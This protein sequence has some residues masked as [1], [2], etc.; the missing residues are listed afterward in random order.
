METLAPWVLEEIFLKKMVN[1][2]EKPSFLLEF[3]LDFSFI[4]VNT[5]FE[6]LFFSSLA[7]KNFS[8]LLEE[9]QQEHLMEQLGGVLE[10]GTEFQIELELK[11]ANG[12]KV[13]YFL[14][15]QKHILDQ[16][17]VELLGFLIP[18]SHHKDMEEKLE[19]VDAYFNALQEL[20]EDLLFMIDIESKTL[21]RHSGKAKIFGLEEKTENFPLSVCER[22]LIHPDYLEKY[23][24]FGTLALEGKEGNTEVLMRQGDGSFHHYQILWTPVMKKNGTVGEV[25]GKMLNIQSMRDL[26]EKANFDA[27]TS[28]LNKQTMCDLTSRFLEDSTEN[29][30]HALFFIDLDDFKRVN[31]SFGHSFGD[32]L[33]KSLGKRFIQNTRSG[34]FIGRVGGDEFVIFLR[35]IPSVEL[36]IR[37]AKTILHAIHEDV[38]QNGKTHNIQASI[39]IAMYPDHGKSYEEL[40]HCADLALYH[41]KGL[42]KN[43]ATIYRPQDEE[44]S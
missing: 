17:K 12:T 4:Q 33:L 42:G 25:F 44:G 40:Y 15:V 8:Q 20:S 29:D 11:Q 36:L 2:T 28:T 22:G 27:L 13:W 18:I 5:S 7:M 38:S 14:D 21:M 6:A 34:D 24:E 10:S 37:K 31:D 41:S 39:G 32:Y 16:E 1:N 35:D 23:M 26:E 3:D 9:S 19:H 30:Y 43:V